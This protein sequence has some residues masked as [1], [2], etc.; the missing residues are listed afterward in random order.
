MCTGY[1]TG[2]DRYR[3]DNMV[4]SGAIDKASP[5]SGEALVDGGYP[6]SAPARDAREEKSDGE[7]EPTPKGPCPIRSKTYFIPR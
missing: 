4:S 1:L 2:P 5:T 7:G 3:P 6:E